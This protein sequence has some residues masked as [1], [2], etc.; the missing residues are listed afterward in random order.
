MRTLSRPVLWPALALCVASCGR[1]DYDPS[2]AG[3]G[4][5][6]AIDARIPR[7]APA[8]KPIDAAPDAFDGDPDARWW[9]RAWSH[10]VRLTIDTSQL[11]E[12]LF[13]VPVA[14]HLDET[15]V[16]P[17]KVQPSGADLRFVAA[18]NLTVL[19]HEIETRPTLSETNVIG[20]AVIWVKLPELKVAAGKSYFWVY[21]GNPTAVDEQRAGKVWSS[22]YIGVWHLGQPEDPREDATGHGNALA[23]FGPIPSV[24]GRLGD[25][26][27]LSVDVDALPLKRP[28]LD[29]SGNEVS[30]L[31]VEAWIEPDGAGVIAAMS[32]GADA[33]TFELYRLPDGVVEFA[34]A[35]TCGSEFVLEGGEPVAAGAWHHV[36][37]TFDGEKMRLYQNGQKTAELVVDQP[38]FPPCD[39]G[40]AFTLGALDGGKGPFDGRVDELRVSACTRSSEWLRVQ[41][42]ATNDELVSYGAQEAQP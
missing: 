22:N 1:I 3:D 40:A 25:G 21:Y 7:D 30:G 42:L 5:V 29:T 23:G 10:R 15:R 2:A 14:V 26:L 31:T 20:T 6:P 36:A 11:G 27:D 4:G 24:E 19:D 39:S 16:D 12:D 41:A 37:A 8:P 32:D 9:D 33:R 18:D 17:A 34:L 28:V 38:R 35:P 13:D